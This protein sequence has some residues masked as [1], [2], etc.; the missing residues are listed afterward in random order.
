MYFSIYLLLCYIH[1]IFIDTDAGS[2]IDHRLMRFCSQGVLQFIVI[3]PA[4]A[5]VD[6][7][8]LA[9]GRFYESIWQTLVTIIY[10]VSYIWA[11]YCLYV[12]YLATHNIIEKFHPLAK[13]ATVK[14]I[15]FATYYQSLFLQV[16]STYVLPGIHIGVWGAG[17]S[18]ALTYHDLPN[19]SSI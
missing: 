12:F 7:V 11:L 16:T 14:S 4:V 17:R 3:K 8:L 9:L 15:I 1:H 2:G 6:L 18:T 10:N 19:E 5:V 13:F